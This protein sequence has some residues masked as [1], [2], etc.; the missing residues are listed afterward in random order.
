[1]VKSTI[2]VNHAKPRQG[3]RMA[4][5]MFEIANVNQSRNNVTYTI[6]HFAILDEENNVKTLSDTTTKTIDIDTYNNLSW[7]AESMMPNTENMT[8]FE[9][10]RLKLKIGLFIFLQTDFLTDEQGNSLDV[11][12][13]GLYPNQIEMV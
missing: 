10:E 3:T 13:Y 4:K 12:A 8:P 2:L 7:Y 1:M 5:V 11:I 9:I 6:E